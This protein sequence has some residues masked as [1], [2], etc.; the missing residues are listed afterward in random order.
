[1]PRAQT[2]GALRSRDGATRRPAS[3][4]LRVAA[5]CLRISAKALV[6]GYTARV[7][8]PPVGGAKGSL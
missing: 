3:A 8:P 5:R 4:L 2:D 6:G 1:M 7:P